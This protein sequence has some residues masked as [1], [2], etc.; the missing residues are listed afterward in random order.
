VRALAE[1]DDFIGMAAYSTDTPGIG[2]RLRESPEDFQV[3]EVLVG[4]SELP[5]RPAPRPGNWVWGVVRKR[6]IDTLTMVERLAGRLGVPLD[7]VSYGGLKDANAVTVQIV[8]VLGVSPSDFLGAGDGYF[9][10]LDAFTMDGPCTSK[11]I[12]G[13]AFNIVVRGAREEGV[14]DALSQARE[15]GVPNF[16]GYQRFGTRRPNTHL[17]GRMIVTGDYEGAV[18]EIAGSPRPGE[19]EPAREARELFDAGKVGEALKEFPRG[20]RAERI[21]ASHLLR[22]GGDYVGALRRLPTDLLRLYVESYQSYLFNKSLSER[23]VRGLPI[24]SAVAGDS[25]LL[26]DESGLPTVHRAVVTDGVRD[27]IN[28]LIRRGRAAVASALIGFRTGESSL[29]E[30]ER[31][32]LR[33]EG[34]SAQ[35]FKIKSIPEA[36]AS[37]GWRILD[38]AP[39]VEEVKLSPLSLRFVLRRGMYATALMRELMKPSDPVECGC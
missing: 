38:S 26:L 19:P 12:Y 15:R 18:R 10:V 20:Y 32:M 17:I 31:E 9:Q 7:R 4:G 30:W 25:V 14:W 21:V 16:F 2:G 39:R 33:N 27:R 24:N 1:L 5:E 37:G 13:N 11:S 3:R 28:E 6:G 22:R 36:S 8:S 34:V 35:S 23:L 29:M